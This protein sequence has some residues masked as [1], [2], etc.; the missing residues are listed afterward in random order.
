MVSAVCQGRAC[1]IERDRA[2]SSGIERD[3][4]AS[5]KRKRASDTTSGR[6]GDELAKRT[7]PL[8]G[9]TESFRDPSSKS[10]H[11][12]AMPFDVLSSIPLDPARCR[13]MSLD[14][15]SPAKGLTVW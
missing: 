9:Q 12:P 6:Y 3:R 11:P 4:A 14:L 7:G 10:I 13:S 8:D 5:P 1:G 15:E 2:T